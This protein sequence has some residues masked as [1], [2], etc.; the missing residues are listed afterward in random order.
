M[1]KILFLLAFVTLAA[2]V[3]NLAG[4]VTRAAL[5]L[6]HVSAAPIDTQSLP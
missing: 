6:D 3:G 5:D 1:L 2:A 4:Q